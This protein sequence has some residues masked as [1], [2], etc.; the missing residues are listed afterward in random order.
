LVPDPARTSTA[1]AAT[2]IHDAFSKGREFGAWLGFVPKQISTG[3]RTIVGSKSRRGNRYLRSL[4]VQ[5][6]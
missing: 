1:M 5:A 4:F 6:A 2:G 3:D